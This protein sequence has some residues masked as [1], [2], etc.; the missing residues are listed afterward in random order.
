MTNMYRHFI[1]NIVIVFL[2][3]SLMI[4]APILLSQEF[5][6]K[7][8]TD[9]NVGKY[10][11]FINENAPS[12]DAFIAVQRIAE[13]YIK[14]K[15]WQKAIDVYKAFKPDFPDMGKRFDKIIAILEAPE[16]H[17][18]AINLGTGV[19]TKAPEYTPIPSADELNLYFTAYNRD[20]KNTKE[21]IYM[22][23]YAN[24]IWQK[25]VKLP[26]P[27]NTKKNEAPQGISVDGN[28]LTI[29]GN[30]EGSYGGGDLFVSEKTKNGWGQPK[31]LPFPI[32][33]QWF[34]C[35][36]KFTADGKAIVF[37]SDRPG[38]IG[39]MH[40]VH[41]FFHGGKNGN[42]DIY[43]CVK[44]DS[45]WSKPINLGPNVNTP[46][47]ERK[48]FLHPD[49]KSIYF[50]S[51]GHA[52]IGRL[53]IFK[54]TKLK[55]DSWTEWSEPINLG[56]E[57]N[58]VEDDW[59]AIVSTDGYI[60]YFAASNRDVCYGK[61]DLYAI[62]MPDALRPEKVITVAGKVTDDKGKPM[63]AE[64]V[65]EDLETGKQ[66][67]KLKS[68]PK[69]G[70]YFIVLPLGKHYGFYALQEGYF[71]ITQNVDLTKTDFF[72]GKKEDM[73]IIALKNLSDTSVRINNVFFDYDKYDLKS[74][75]FPELDRLYSLLKNSNFVK[76][77]ISG[78]TDQIGSVDYNMEL[79]ER[80]A[81]A[82]VDYLVR[83]GIKLDRM[84]AKGYG[85]SHP[86]TLENTEEAMAL[87]RRVEFKL[88]TK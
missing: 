11:D 30:Y 82:V 67:G 10:F 1:K 57:I 45:G 49:G 61:S 44:T 53:D 75:S 28:Q 23:N 25:A 32:N 50:S 77:E 43:V 78:H 80:R 87:N 18:T 22:S 42:T 51:E 29:F 14:K 37:V 81:K 48:P 73:K 69:D 17:L 58:T 47:A 63:S 4:D 72:Y 64:I 20:G 76:V 55:E 15:E 54:C 13:P 84:S 79:S 31:Q 21:D 46:Y 3:V 88:I 33:S 39:E 16:E 9:D 66:V 40:R 62:K 68:N 74:T 19:N 36:A 86:V 34:D 38:G 56:K 5:L 8:C 26:S 27:I 6:M 65:W 85:K 24:G 70:S 52:G 35:D 71:P 60:A 41:Q 12:E 2:F 7:G 83:K 59:G